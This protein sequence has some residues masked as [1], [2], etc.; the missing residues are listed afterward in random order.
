M[1]ELRRRS[2]QSEQQTCEKIVGNCSAM[3]EIYKI[4]PKLA[5]AN[6]PVLIGGESGT[7]KELIAQGGFK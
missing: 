5:A 1:A 7:G 6:A 2:F 4:I 3:R